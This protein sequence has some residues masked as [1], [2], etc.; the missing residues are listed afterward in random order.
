M[1]D[2]PRDGETLGEVIMRGNNA[3]KGYFDH[4]D[5]T[6]EAFRVGWFHSGDLAVSHPDGY[7]ELRDPKKDII[8]SERANISTIEVEQTVAGHPA[9]MDGGERRTLR[10]LLGWLAPESSRKKI[11]QECSVPIENGARGI[12]PRGKDRPRRRTHLPHARGRGRR[13]APAR[14]CFQG[15]GD[16]PR[17]RN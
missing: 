17:A 12:E 2:V 16:L 11:I 6:A 9:V 3:M 14:E 10:A 5:A 15:R 8:I 1:H 4:R 13:D 7:I